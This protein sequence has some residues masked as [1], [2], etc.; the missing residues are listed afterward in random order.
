MTI[1][2]NLKEDLKRAEQTVKDLQNY[3]K[4]ILQKGVGGE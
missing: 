1:I 3:K 4:D 2:E